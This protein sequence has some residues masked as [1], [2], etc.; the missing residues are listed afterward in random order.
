MVR[1]RSSGF[2][3]V[4]LLVVIAI[5]GILIALLLP[6]VQSAR[7]AARRAQ[8]SNNL[9]QMGLAVHNYHDRNNEFPPV[10]AMRQD[11]SLAFPGNMATVM[12]SGN[13]AVTMNDAVVI[14]W[15]GMILPYMEGGPTFDT[16]RLFELAHTSA[17]SAAIG[18]FRYEG[19]YCPT[20][21]TSGAAAYPLWNN[22]E[23]QMTDYGP[24]VTSGW[25]PNSTT[26]LG[27]HE[28]NGRPERADGMFSPPKADARQATGATN[29][30]ILPRSAT[31]F[32]S[33][34]DGLSYTA[35]IG[36]KHML[37][38]GT[39]FADSQTPPQLEDVRDWDGAALVYGD[40]NGWQ[41]RARGGLALHPRDN[42]GS[43]DGGG[44]KWGSWHPGQTLFCRGDASVERV[45]NFIDENSLRAFHTRA[46]G[47]AFQLP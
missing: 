33:C 1:I 12:N 6:A 32:G 30:S 34:Q 37:A 38:D 13:Q 31:T 39:R 19:Y 20:R 23:A 25:L 17:N 45:K 21:R 47:D 3:L 41:R 36:E 42:V 10:S 22:V 15:M 18:T 16:F 40:E 4:E 14:G 8:C 28:V 11:F 46:N 29:A 7:E 27:T 26:T 2:T 5:I 44:G 9:R 24:V 43:D 35:I